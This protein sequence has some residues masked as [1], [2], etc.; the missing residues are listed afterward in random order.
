MF[1]LFVLTVLSGLELHSDIQFLAARLGRVATYCLPTI[2]FLTLRPSPL[3]DT[4]YLSLLPIH[5]WLSRI[6][7]FQCIAHTALYVWI[8]VKRDTIP[9]IW[10][11]D[12]LYGIYALIAFVLIFLT[13]LPKIRRKLYNLFFAFHYIC[14]WISVLT[15]YVH[16]RPS[17]PYLTTLNVAILLYQ[18][19][20]RY[21]ISIIST[22]DVAQLSSNLLLVTVPNSA[23]ASKSFIPGCHLRMIE[24]EESN[25]FKQLWRVV[26][27]PVQHPYTIS[28]LPIDQEQQ[29]IVRKGKFDICP[30]K[31]YIITGA[32]LPY[33]NFMKPVKSLNPRSLLF[34]TDVKKCLIVVGGSAISFALPILRTLSYN[35]VV[36]KIIWVLKDHE[37]LKVLDFYQNILVNDDCIDIFITGK[38]TGEEIFN[39]KRAV[40]EL[41]RF[42]RQSELIN[43]EQM[44]SGSYPPNY[45]EKSPLFQPKTS[46]SATS[47][48]T[49]E[50]EQ[51][52][53]TLN[54]KIGYIPIKNHYEDTKSGYNAEDEDKFENVDLDLEGKC[55]SPQST[56]A[57]KY[58]LFS[59]ILD[60][61]KAVPEQR[62]PSN[63]SQ[64]LSSGIYDDLADY[65][66]LKGLP[67]RIEFGRPRLGLYYYNWCIGSSCIGPL[68]DL[69]SGES[70][71]CNE[72]TLENKQ[73]TLQ[74]KKS[75]GQMLGSNPQD[76][77]FL[78]EQFMRNRT[79]RFQKR[80]GKLD[81]TTLVV[82][83]GP[84][85]LVNKV[86]LWAN[87]CGFQFHAESFSV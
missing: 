51:E 3:P 85:G 8:F 55:R 28:T 45:H 25:F 19:Y 35:G 82:G 78:N 37:D 2:L 76:D 29:L 62:T 39:F 17:I 49:P 74:Y 66:I 80:G 87:D 38:Y 59:G 31:K 75:N 14:T 21:K 27:A 65:W 72:V 53:M 41:H 15:L 18:I 13:S 83:A 47:S 68:V 6:I 22:V 63:V 61:P 84:T 81:E 57:R 70:V 69:K 7:I 11:R 24:Y 73:Q 79:E 30:G 43:Q 12:N 77:L 10:K 36:V 50:W 34:N 40:R 4:L 52:H 56:T 5:K 71:C 46:Y 44:L 33:L 42:N 54:S 23:I 64:T 9:K 48:D 26:F 60:I 16:V 1:W 58:S 86:R 20:Y 32:Y 67:C